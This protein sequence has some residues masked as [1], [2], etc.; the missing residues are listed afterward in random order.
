MKR[1]VATL[2]LVITTCLSS[3]AS[4]QA[5]QSPAQAPP[6]VAGDRVSFLGDSIFH[7][8]K[9]HSN[10]LLFYAT[11]FP[12]S[13]LAIR[14]AGVAG[15]MASGAVTRVDW[16]VKPY[17]PHRD[18]GDVRHERRRPLALWRG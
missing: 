17:D 11:R 8:G 10:L 15:D 7:G 14:N 9:V 16:D 2:L 3:V 12:D 5:L 1:F 4:A 18:G 6:F 13:P